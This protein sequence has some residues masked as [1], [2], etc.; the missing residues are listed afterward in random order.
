VM[1]NGSSRLGHILHTSRMR[2]GGRDRIWINFI[3]NLKSL[4]GNSPH[5]VDGTKQARGMI[6]Q[7]H[8]YDDAEQAQYSGDAC[9][10]PR[11]RIDSRLNCDSKQQRVDE[12]C[13]RSTNAPVAE[14]GG[15][16][17]SRA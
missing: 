14:Q 4:L 12:Q 1:K 9:K 13:D 10:E 8:E 16:N 5:Y 11:Y 15:C 6:D 17:N 7:K 2:G 3:E